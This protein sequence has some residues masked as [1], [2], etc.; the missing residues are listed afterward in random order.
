MTKSKNI[1]IILILISII[2]T[3]IVYINLPDKI[4]FHWNIKGEIDA[5]TNKSFAWLTA[6][7]PLGVYLLMIYIPAIDP[8]RESYLKH[9]KAYGIFTV[10]LVLFFVL[11]HW[12]VMLT[13]L[14]YKISISRIIPTGIGLLFIL[15]GNFMG[16]IRP[17]YS[18][19][20]KTP[21]TLADDTVWKKTHRVGGLSFILSGIIFII[22]GIVNHPSVF[23]L[24][25][26]SIFL[27]VIYI[28]LYS[29]LEYKKIKGK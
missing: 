5:W 6:I 26:G 21:W 15:I 14:G 7:L 27:A 20:I 1:I 29:Y 2:G 9:K 25:I 16:Q 18:L 28:F 3:A 23:I 22:A 19:G 13:G 4:P 17:N 12:V 8:R 11:M 24:A 10:I